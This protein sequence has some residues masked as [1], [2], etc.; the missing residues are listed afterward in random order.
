MD[1][2]LGGNELTRVSWQHIRWLYYVL[3][4]QQTKWQRR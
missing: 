1:G 3:P 2:A 4:P